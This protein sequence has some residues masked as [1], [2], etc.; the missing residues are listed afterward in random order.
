MNYSELNEDGILI[1]LLKISDDQYLLWQSSTLEV[2]NSEVYFEFNDQLSGGYNNIKEIT[3]MRDGIHLVMKNNCLEHFYFDK[4]F[5]DYS[6]LA[7]GLK[8]IYKNN[9]KNL[10]ILDL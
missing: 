4:K 3:L 7:S 8:K 5:D 6:A 9:L 10:D 1:V 2:D